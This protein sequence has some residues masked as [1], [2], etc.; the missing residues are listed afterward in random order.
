MHSQVQAVGVIVGII[1]MEL[2]SYLLIP[3]SQVE[4]RVSCLWDDHMHYPNS[5]VFT[6][7]QNSSGTYPKATTLVTVLL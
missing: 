1:A 7:P 2:A 6:N 4:Y 5:F 3:G